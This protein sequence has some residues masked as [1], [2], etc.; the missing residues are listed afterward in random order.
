MTDRE[1]LVQLILDASGEKD[2]KK[3]IDCATAFGLAKKHGLKLAD[4]GAACNEENIKIINCQLGCFQ[5]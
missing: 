2:G 3:R 1:K 5:E 4:I